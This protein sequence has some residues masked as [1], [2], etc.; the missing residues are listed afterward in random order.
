MASLLATQNM[1][2][3]IKATPESG[4]GAGADVWRVIYRSD[5]D[6]FAAPS[7]DSTARTVDR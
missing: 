2:N 6:A 1:A 4:A 5:A 3:N 7:E